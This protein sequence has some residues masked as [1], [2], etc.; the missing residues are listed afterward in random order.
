MDI[1]MPNHILA[2]FSILHSCNG[3]ETE[4]W[5][6]NHPTLPTVLPPRLQSP[7]E[8][9]GRLPGQL[10][11]LALSKLRNVVFGN[12]MSILTLQLVLVLRSEKGNNVDGPQE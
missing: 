3:Q 7:G 11:L 4:S 12:R 10:V 1:T 6:K 8:K 9:S 2:D 5:N